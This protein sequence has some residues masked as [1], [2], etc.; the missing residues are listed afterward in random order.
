MDGESV[1]IEDD[2]DLKM[3]YEHA[4][5]HSNRIKILIQP[6]HTSPKPPVKPSQPD[7]KFQEPDEPATPNQK[8]K[9]PSKRPPSEQSFP[10][11]ALKHL[12]QTELPI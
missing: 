11:K 10:R 9:R 7:K 12:I 2:S 8:P 5:S 6:T 4:L 3:A 1:V